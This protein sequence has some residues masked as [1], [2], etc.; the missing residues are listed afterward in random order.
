M[1]LSR[2][3]VILLEQGPRVLVHQLAQ[4]DPER[5]WRVRRGLMINAGHLAADDGK[6]EE[7]D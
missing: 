2:N 4:D 6:D 1:G 3:A 7:Q 5:G